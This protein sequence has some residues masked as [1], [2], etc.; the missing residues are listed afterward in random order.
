MKPLS[1]PLQQYW[2]TIAE[3]L[4]ESV[5]GVQAKSVLTFSDFVR[6]S[7]IA[8]PHWLTE[9]ESAP[10][11]ADEWQ[12]YGEWLQ[13]ALA[14][15]N[16]EAALM[17]E[18][19]LFRR[20]VM[21]RIAWA[22]ALSLVDDTDILQQLSH[23]AETLIVSARDWLYDACCREWGTP[24]SQD[25]IPQP[26]LILGM[27]KLGGGELNFS[28][29]IDLIFA[30][31]EHGS[32]QGGRRELDNAQFFTR[33]GQRLIKVLDQPTQDGFV[34]RVDMRLRPFGDSGP[35]VLSFAALEDYYQEQGRD[36]ERYAMVKAR[37]MGDTDGRYVDELRAML[38]PFVFR[39][40]IDFSVIQSLR[41]MKGMI[42][43]EVRRRG[44]KDNIKLG[45]GGIRE[46]EFIVQV[47]QLIRGGREP[48]LQS[49]SL[50]PTLS[51]IAALHLLPENDAE[52]LR[53]A[54]LFLRR[55]ENL[56]QSINDEQTQTLPGDE[57]N[58]ARLAWGMNA[59]NWSQ[60]METLEGHM[61]N[62]RRVFNE[63][64]GDDE[65]DTQEDALS[66]QW[67][68]LWQDALQEDD[69][70]P[71]LS[72]LT[73][74]DRLRVLALIADFRKELDKR[75][76]GPRGRQ[77]LD[78]LMP[79]LLSDVCTRQDA[80]L[81]LSRITPL[82]VGIV[83]RTTYLELL[84]EFPGALKH[85]ISLC[86]AS[87]MVASQLARYPLLLDELL[88]PNTLYQPTATDAYRD[89][90]RQYLL[91]VPE[92]DEEQQLEALRQ[93]KQT[94]L[95]R[96]AAAD[97]AG[98][99]PVM[100]VSD[101]L[102]WLAEAMIDAVVQQAW[103][104]MV[105]RYGQPTHLA[106]REGRG[107]AVV[108]YGKLGGW[109]LGYSSD[110]D[111][112]FLH[113]CPVDVMTDGEREIDGRQFYLRLAQR[114]MHLFSTRTS[115]G[116][117][118][119]VDARLRPSGAAG[120]LV[121]ST[122]S[123]ADYQKNEA[124]TWEHQALV[125]ARVVYGDPQLT[126]QFDS[127]R[128]DI[129]TQPR[130]GKTLQN[131]VR[132]MREK[133]RAHLGNK[134]RD[135]FDI[136]ADEGGITDIEFITQYLVLRYAHDKP[137]LTRWSDNVRILELLAQNDIMDEQEAMALTHAYTTLRDELHHLALQELPGHVA[138]TCFEAERTLVRASWQ[139]WLVEE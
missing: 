39:R 31:P 27:G 121:T 119:E 80:S 4:P 43:R 91:R 28:S 55:L 64:I 94:Q 95:L 96:I 7:I 87:P 115:S 3:Q 25:G 33:M 114:I 48:S 17:H 60:L 18:L 35:L 69:T 132:E 139:K 70:P 74:D 5:S 100:K 52:Q 59:D 47:F 134:H 16:D 135:R 128:R 50:L 56:L 68:E 77:V 97:I 21:V 36:W 76:I 13:A 106:E 83:T 108:G 130:D 133:M 49:R 93:F 53:L 44:L 109:E 51:A 110:L 92:D 38:R 9:L 81:P 104:Q 85:L 113:D 112:I 61:A 125:R 122:E 11:Q 34:Y 67:R 98:T 79:H 2:Q 66:E 30:W 86:A 19:R 20:R 10:P 105:A 84:S 6:D 24:C 120:M 72:H 22:Q 32:T 8:H 41:N 29:D 71:V 23:L 90:L 101:H 99:L 124:W 65:T 46:I 54:Y 126:S 89:E 40:Y 103:L 137:K 75:T 57:L 138:Q 45:A 123:F 58:R 116:I 62:V 129:M 127:V 117:L 37:I 12:Q 107:F 14:T 118:Y 63:L 88:D 26:L 131:E 15:V 78:H 102:T 42:A 82:L 73:D 111:L 136:K 1:S